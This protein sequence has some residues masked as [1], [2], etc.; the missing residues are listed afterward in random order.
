MMLFRLKRPT[1]SNTWVTE[2][3]LLIGSFIAYILVQSVLWWQGWMAV[4]AS[5]RFMACI[6]PLGAFLAVV[7]LDVLLSY[8]RKWKWLTNALLVIIIGLVIYVPYTLNEIPAPLIKGAELM[9]KTANAFKYLDRENKRIVYFDPKFTFYLNEDPYA[10]NKV[11]MGIPD[12]DL[13]DLGLVDSAYLVWDTHFAEFER[14]LSLEYLLNSPH[15]QLIDGFLPTTEFRFFTGRYFMSYIF[16]KV[17]AKRQAD[18]FRKVEFIDFED[19]DSPEKEKKLSKNVAFSG[20]HSNKMYAEQIYSISVRKQLK[21]LSTSKKVIFWSSI[22]ALIP[23]GADPEKLLLVLEVRQTS[24]DMFRYYA[25]PASFFKPKFNEWSDI[26]IVTPLQIDIPEDGYIK[27]YAWYNG[28]DSVFVDDMN[29][30][31]LDIKETE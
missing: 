25:V 3:F 21:E 23:E 5:N 11:H 27:L 31:V 1:L 8:T 20:N 4:L 30:E 16:Q 24:N 6:M 9:K 14:K 26:S 7:G 19:F 13:E 12:R 2:Y 22:K 15:F 29:L 10:T 17:P 18:Q 28:K